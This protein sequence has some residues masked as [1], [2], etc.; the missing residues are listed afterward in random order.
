M[1]M[2]YETSE[3]FIIGCVE[4]YM[5]GYVKLFY[6]TDNFDYGREGAST[7]T[8]VTEHVWVN[9][10]KLIRRKDLEIKYV[11]NLGEELK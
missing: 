8:I 9:K 11:T 3:G 5:A 2:M 6:S 10:R 4:D 1:I 7:S